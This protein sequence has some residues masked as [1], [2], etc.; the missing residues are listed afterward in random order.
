MKRAAIGLTGKLLI[1]ICLIALLSGCAKNTGSNSVNLPEKTD[2]VVVDFLG[3]R[4]QVPEK[5][6]R[7]ACLYAMSGQIVVM[8][9][10]GSNIVAVVDGLKRDVLLTQLAPN[11]KNAATPSAG[12]VINI[13]ELM[14][15]KPDVIFVSSD[16]ARNP[17]E[18]AKLEKSKIP[19]FVVDCNTVVEQQQVID[20]VG[21]VVGN[22]EK[23]RKYQEYYQHI[24]IMVQE[25]VAGI[26]D[27]DK[28]KIYHSILEPTKTDKPRT[29]S[30]DWIKYAGAVNVAATDLSSPTDSDNKFFVNVEQILLWDPDVIIV[31][32]NG[33]VDEIMHD[34]QWASVR[35]VKQG[36]VYQMPVGIS[37]WGHPGSIETPLAILWT[38]KL[39]Y[40]DRFSDVNMAVETRQFYKDYFNLELTDDNLAMVLNGKGKLKKGASAGDNG[41]Q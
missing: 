7:I 21:T 11:I 34:P 1:I 30:A 38:A 23:A 5:V 25:R 24:M 15:I 17:V 16:V 12:G 35:A 32:E 3:R 4:I 20:M 9:D 8:L 14:K 41:K 40:P 37:R 39:L 36:K 18:A 27:K 26:P 31:N 29:L 10:K 28:M 13:E 2:N 33:A 6:D 22:R 19:Y